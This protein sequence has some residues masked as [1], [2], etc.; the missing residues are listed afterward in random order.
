MTNRRIRVSRLQENRSTNGKS[1]VLDYEVKTVRTIVDCQ[2]N[3]LS[4]LNIIVSALW[5]ILLYI[6]Q[7]FS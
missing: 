5:E 7:Y 4:H 1:R 3:F 2:K 6:H